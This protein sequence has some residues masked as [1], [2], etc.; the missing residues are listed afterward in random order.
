MD[1][2][3]D[4][5]TGGWTV[6]KRRLSLFIVECTG[7]G[8]PRKLPFCTQNNKARFRH[9]HQMLHLGVLKGSLFA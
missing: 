5:W 6:V 7:S 3:M 4:K 1:G 8:G 2:Q 9:D